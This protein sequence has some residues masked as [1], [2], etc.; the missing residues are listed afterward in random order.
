MSAVR[1]RSQAVIF[2]Q[3]AVERAHVK[4]AELEQWLLSPETL[5]TTLHEVEE[6]Q[7]Y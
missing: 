1:R 2:E 4:F 6:E 5:G 7:E 3:S